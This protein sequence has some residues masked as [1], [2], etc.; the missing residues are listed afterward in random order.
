M[1]VF[2]ME[3]RNGREI[4]QLAMDRIFGLL[5]LLVCANGERSVKAR[6]CCNMIN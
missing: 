4:L 6:P 5:L 1:T 3:L 2:R